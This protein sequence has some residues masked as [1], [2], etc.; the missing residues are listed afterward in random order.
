MT[1]AR[2]VIPLPRLPVWIPVL[3]AVVRLRRLWLPIPLVLLWPLL[4]PAWA[5]AAAFVTVLAARRGA[6]V[7]PALWQLWCA[8][9]ALRGLHVDISPAPRPAVEPRGASNRA[10]ARHQGKSRPARVFVWIV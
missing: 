6:P 3:L 10:A 1:A 9:G 8:L 2:P 5:V 7:G 4:L